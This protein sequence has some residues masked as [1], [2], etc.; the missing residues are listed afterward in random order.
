MEYRN[1]GRSGLQV[2][3]VGLGTNNFGGRM[4]AKAT[5]AVVNEALD[6]GINLFDE[7]DIYGGRGRSEEFF[8]QALGSR[9][10]EAVVATKFGQRM[11]EGT[12]E[13]G[14][15]RRWIMQAVEDSLRRLNTDYIDLYQ[16]HIPDP[17][18][19]QDETLRALD[20]LV[21]QGKVRYLGN[22]NY[23]GWQ[24]ADGAW[25]AKSE[26]RTPYVSAQNAYSLLDRRA[27]ADV[28][29]ALKHFGLSLIP[30]GPLAG[31]LLTGKYQRG[32]AAPEGVRLAS[33]PQAERL[34]TDRNFDIVDD[35]TKFAEERGH[36]ILELAFCWLA[37]M[38]YVG[39]VIAGATT[40]EQVRANVAAAEWRLTPVEMAEV[41]KIT[42]R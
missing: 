40:P 11:G 29:P 21:T 7:A 37:T 8:G 12:M 27:D 41:D 6:M 10:H 42:L 15:S 32:E 14:A 36:T 24:I 5:D 22:S 38:P 2:S 1:L 9:R 30:W 26:H 39:S 31:G 17:N 4:D 35:L 33:G 3:V 16:V 23:A 18:T 28:I 19:P 34:L 13:G 25:V 20:D